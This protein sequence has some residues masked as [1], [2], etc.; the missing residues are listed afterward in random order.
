MPGHAGRLGSHGESGVWTRSFTALFLGQSVSSI[1]DAFVPLASSFAILHAGGSA[2]TVGLLFMTGLIAR[3]CSLLIGGVWADRLPRVITMVTSDLLRAAVQ[4][5]VAVAIIEHYGGVWPIFL[6]TIMYYVAAGFFTPAAGRIIPEILPAG[7]I[8]RANGLLSASYQSCQIAGQ[9]LSGVVVATIG[10]GVAFVI[11]A[12]S[13]LASALIVMQ[14]TGVAPSRAVGGRFWQDFR[15]GWSEILRRRWYCFNLAMHALWNMGTAAFFVLG[16]VIMVRHYGG[17]AA[18]G[19]TLAGIS[20]GSVAGGIATAS[21]RLKR[22]AVVANAAGMLAA[23]PLLLLAFTRPLYLLVVG[24]AVAY[25]GAG[26][27][28]GVWRSMSQQLLTI[29]M[30]SRVTASNWIVSLTAAPLG[31]GLAGPCASAF[32]IRPTLEGAAGITVLVS[33]LLVGWA[34]RYRVIRADSGIFQL[35]RPPSAPTPAVSGPG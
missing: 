19:I 25:A 13:F 18:W 30:M 14:V 33:V 15:V 9:V 10:P 4:G 24:G 17:S 29:D 21:L 1:G 26:L 16:P 27:L 32:G 7:A 12:V 5:G 22:T 34:L 3:I 20:A 35:G 11:D 28:D 2:T 8:Q 31:Y 23:L 6:G